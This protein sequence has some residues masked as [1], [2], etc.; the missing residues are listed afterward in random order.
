[1]FRSRKDPVGS[2]SAK[3]PLVAAGSG[4]SSVESHAVSAEQQRFRTLLEEFMGQQ[5]SQQERFL[6]AITKAHAETLE[7]LRRIEKIS[8]SPP[9]S[10]KAAAGFALQVNS[11]E[12]KRDDGYSSLATHDSAADETPRVDA[13]EGA[14][15]SAHTKN[16][17]QQLKQDERVVENWIRCS[18]LHT[19]QDWVVDYQNHPA[20]WAALLMI[21]GIP[22]VTG[23][24]RSKVD[25][26]SI[27]SAL[28]L[29]MSVMCLATPADFILS[30]TQ[31]EVGS[32]SWWY[33]H[34][35]KRAYLYG[36]G[37]GTCCHTL[38]IM[39]G[40]AFNG[41]L[42]EAAR[43]SDVFRMF[44]RG[45][46]FLATV[47][48][49]TAFFCGCASDYIAVLAVLSTIVHWAELAIAST[50]MIGS[51][52]LIYC[53]TKDLLFSTTSIVNYWRTCPDENDPFDLQLMVE[54]FNER[55]QAQR[56][57]RKVAADESLD[58]EKKSARMRTYSHSAPVEE[59]M[60]DDMLTAV[61]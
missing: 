51:C 23:R 7:E 55:S 30:D 8:P 58:W 14:D 21:L 45:K 47:K 25:N 5:R 60:A 26:F 13:S 27:Y 48:S 40:M 2:D 53:Q 46:G 29:S 18:G 50:V 9:L 43:D 16:V 31:E 34:A 4:S 61:A 1:M 28:F 15:G 3:V 24:L 52:S 12:T 10:P 35:V 33:S 49:E 32:W 39:L 54:C 20:G 17:E 6:D 41:A 56:H 36:F 59:G 37:I 19:V 11:N 42:N 38:C 22:E 57:L 44:S